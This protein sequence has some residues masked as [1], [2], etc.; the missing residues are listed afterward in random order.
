ME[1]RD[2]RKLENN[3][4]GYKRAICPIRSFYARFDG[5]PIISLDGPYIG[6][7]LHEP[8][9]RRSSRTRLTSG[10]VR[11]GRNIADFLFF[12][13]ADDDRDGLGRDSIS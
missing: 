13:H 5:F 1:A 12:Y 8:F 10:R 6:I 4:R 7:V 3:Y 11:A 2:I 9:S